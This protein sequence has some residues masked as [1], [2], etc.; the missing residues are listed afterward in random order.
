ME[1]ARCQ[2]ISVV[3]F[4]RQL[5][6]LFKEGIPLGAALEGLVIQQDQRFSA[7][8]DKVTSLITEGHSLSSSLA[9]FPLV[10][11][12]VYIA[13][14]AVGEKTGG[15]HQALD[16]LANWMERDHEWAQRIRSATS[17]PLFIIA[18][19]LGMTLLLF[20]S[21]M[22]GFLGIFTD[23]KAEL[24]WLTRMMVALTRAVSNPGVW[25]LVI[26]G[27]GFALMSLREYGRTPRGACA[28][29][30]L[31]L[32]VP[33]VGRLVHSACMARYTC[34]LATMLSG[35]AELLAS[36]QMASQASNSPLLLADS[37]ELVN[38]ITSGKSLSDHMSYHP[39][40]YPTI[41]AYMA[42]VGEESGSMA[43]MFMR[44]SEY[45]AQEVNYQVDTLGATL[46]PLLLA[47]V[48]AMVA[49]IVLSLFLPLY[50]NI[51]QLGV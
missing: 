23:M 33:G 47:L 9:R 6:V 48:G 13:M 5:A 17:Y 45:Y 37:P 20:H 44:V 19:T 26:A 46:E 51:S 7:I 27:G 39:D 35:G 2:P 49:V 4:T 24:P 8:L 32:L 50:T 21:V 11:G 42:K 43:Q 36:L 34:G 18:L 16:V 30:R 15:L 31:L 10:F 22:P 14:V 1:S 41:L 38:S 3:L 12:R 28:L 40:T 25:I 29:Y